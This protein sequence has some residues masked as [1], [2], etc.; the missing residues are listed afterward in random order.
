VDFVDSSPDGEAGGWPW[1]TMKPLSTAPPSAHKPHRP[2][3]AMTK[4][5]KVKTDRFNS[6]LW[7][8]TALPSRPFWLAHRLTPTRGETLQEKPAGEPRL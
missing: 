2:R 1:I 7:K 4:K 3:S 5:F 8:S 6:P